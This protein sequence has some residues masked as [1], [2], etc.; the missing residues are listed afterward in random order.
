M[1]PHRSCRARLHWHNN[2]RRKRGSEDAAAAAAQA[3]QSATS[4][5]GSCALTD[6]AGARA[7]H[8]AVRPGQRCVARSAG[9]DC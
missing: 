5:G 6:A 7:P 4:G 1:R 9:A 3:A 8:Q 2:K